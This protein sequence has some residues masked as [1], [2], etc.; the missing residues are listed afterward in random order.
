MQQVRSAH[1]PLQF[2]QSLSRSPLASFR[3][4]PYSPSETLRACYHLAMFGLG[5]LR[6]RM[7]AAGDPEA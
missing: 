6:Y 2:F 7:F 4:R 1:L 5:A 3:K